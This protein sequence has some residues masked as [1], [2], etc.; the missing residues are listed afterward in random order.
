MMIVVPILTLVEG[1]TG[2]MR[3]YPDV[4][5][6][7]EIGRREVEQSPCWFCEVVSLHTRLAPFP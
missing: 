1:P 6:K 7:G 2:A 3:A 5:E 4:T